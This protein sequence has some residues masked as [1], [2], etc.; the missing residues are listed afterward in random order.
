MV[1]RRVMTSVS[2]NHTSPVVRDEVV[3]PI[4]TAVLPGFSWHRLWSVDAIPPAPADGSHAPGLEHFPPAGGVRFMV[5]EIPPDQ[6]AKPRGLTAEELRRELEEKLP[7]RSRH[8]DDG[9]SRTHATASIDLIYV[10][11]GEIWLELDDS[12]PIHITAG[13][14]VVQ[15]GARHAWRNHGTQPCVMVG[16]LIGIQPRCGVP[17]RAASA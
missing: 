15:H 10:I 5:F 4:T 2:A 8:F 12:E 16:C 3:E 17:P 6:T 13:D 1:V 7:G 14:T 9:G 11:S